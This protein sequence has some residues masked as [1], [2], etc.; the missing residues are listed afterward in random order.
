MP[1]LEKLAET[2]RLSFRRARSKPSRYP[3]S[4]TGAELAQLKELLRSPGW[5]AYR[6]LLERYADLRA[7][8]LLQ[9]LPLDQT[10]IERGA[11]AALFEIAALPDQLLTH[12]G[13]QNGRQQHDG[14][15]EPAADFSW[16]WGNSLFADRFRHP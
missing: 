6:S 3:L 12:I 2:F 1:L 15:N 8:R 9:P 14:D 10:N 7:Q 16:A 4:L 13:D 11:I 5:A